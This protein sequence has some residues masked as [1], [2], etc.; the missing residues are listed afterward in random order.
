MPEINIKTAPERGTKREAIARAVCRSSLVPLCDWIVFSRIRNRVPAGKVILILAGALVFPDPTW[1]EVVSPKALQAQAADDDRLY[2]LNLQS[3][4]AEL[5]PAEIR[6]PDG[7]MHLRLFTA[8]IEKEGKLWRRLSLRYLDDKGAAMAAAKSLR[9]DYPSTGISEISNVVEVAETS[10]KADSRHQVA[11]HEPRPLLRP[12]TELGT[13]AKSVHTTA[14]VG[15][16][17]EEGKPDSERMLEF[18][19][20]DPPDTRFEITPYLS[21]GAD[22]EVELEVERNL[23]LDRD[24]DADDEAVIDPQLSAAVSFHPSAQFRAFGELELSRDIFLD[25][26]ADRR[27]NDTRLVVKRAYVTVQDWAPGFAAQLGRQRFEEE[28]EWF[29]DEN[30]DAA[31][32]FFQGGRYGAE[33]SISREQLFRRDLLNKT[34]KRDIDN[35]IATG[36]V[37]LG[38]E[39]EARAY[40]ILRD[41][42]NSNPEDL[43][44]FGLQSTGKLTDNL[45]YWAQFAHVRGDQGTNDITGFGI[46]LGATYVLDLP[47]KPA[48]TLGGAFGSGDSNPNNGKDKSFRQTGLQ[49]N[50][51]K[52]N[53]VTS[54]KY[55]GEVFDP[56]L[57]NMA[58]LTAGLGFRPTKKTS[59]DLVYHHF[60]Q[61]KAVDELR[62]SALDADPNGRKRDLGQELNLILGVREFDNVSLELVAG[63]FF[64]GKAFDVR[65]N[66]YFASAELKI[67]F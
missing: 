35:Y 51:M 58:I 49:D 44:F 25:R 14:A 29:Y 10:G 56:E 32:L 26:P 38:E 63:A 39:S 22:L 31:R 50:N 13:G 66:A 43:L 15:Q 4:L 34:R 17:V 20:D 67:K 5:N 55:Y 33:L 53:G 47:F 61:A 9:A 16:P 19:F 65:D 21:F 2:A 28:T 52:F 23:D 57:S 41:D 7:F 37:A 8:E 18:D 42:R 11:V 40:I 46:D 48:I 27:D 64:P 12:R 6:L 30:L 1:S 24:D 3:T 59:L 54:F 45:E 62:D 36:R 60:W